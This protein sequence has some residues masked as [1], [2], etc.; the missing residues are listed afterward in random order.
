[1]TSIYEEIQC[2]VKQHTMKTDEVVEVELHAFLT[3]AVDGGE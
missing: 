3:S 2:L 1:M